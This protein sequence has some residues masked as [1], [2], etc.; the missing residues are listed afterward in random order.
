MLFL[1]M[2][3]LFG[4]VICVMFQSQGMILLLYYLFA[5]FHDMLFLLCYSWVMFLLLFFYVM[6]FF[7]V[8]FSLQFVFII[9]FYVSCWLR[10]FLRLGS[11][12]RLDAFSC[13]FIFCY[14]TLSCFFQIMISVKYFVM[15]CFFMLFFMSF[16]RLYDI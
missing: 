8:V 13:Y 9:F 3:I 15:L 2:L 12:C 1:V 6:L 4:Y 5:M 11:V 14:V 16:C 7:V 10:A